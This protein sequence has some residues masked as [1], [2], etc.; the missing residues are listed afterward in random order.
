MDE[1]CAK[2]VIERVERK[3][4]GAEATYYYC[5]GCDSRRAN[6]SRSRALPHAKACHVCIISSYLTLRDFRYLFYSSNYHQTLQREWP[7]EWNSV[8]NALVEMTT[9]HVVTSQAKAPAV[10]EPSKRKATNQNAGRVE[11]S[12]APPVSSE[13]SSTAASGSSSATGVQSKLSQSWGESKLTAARQAIID[14]HLLRFVVCCSIAF[15]VLDN[16]FFIDFL[17]VL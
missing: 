7:K 5:I 16:G 13:V 8:T 3:D 14:F 15:A 4:S 11:M 2:L 9:E 12:F 6:N 17:S 10:R 1:L